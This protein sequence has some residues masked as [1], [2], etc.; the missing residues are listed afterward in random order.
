MQI[1]INDAIRHLQAANI[2]MTKQRELILEHLYLKLSHPTAEELFE[3]I[4][5]AYPKYVS[6]TTIYKN[7]RTLKELGLLKDFHTHHGDI[8]RYDTN[9]E[10]HHHLYCVH[11]GKIQDF[12]AALPALAEFGDGFRPENAYLEVSGICDSCEQLQLQGQSFKVAI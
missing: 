2:R 11:C 1:T 8:L 10:P 5:A 12:T 7:L 6:M 4:Y 9:T 3:S